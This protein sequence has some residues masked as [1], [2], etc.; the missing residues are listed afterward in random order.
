MYPI[1]T[2]LTIKSLLKGPS[3]NTYCWGNVCQM[4]KI[5]AKQESTVAQVN[6]FYRDKGFAIKQ[7]TSEVNEMEIDGLN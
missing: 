5:A 6:K 4:N 1:G 7:D 2:W 3:S